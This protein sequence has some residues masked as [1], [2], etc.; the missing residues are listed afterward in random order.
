MPESASSPLDDPPT[1]PATEVKSV[2]EQ[3]EKASPPHFS[4]SLSSANFSPNGDLYD[5]LDEDW[6][7]SS[8]LGELSLFD[9]LDGLSIVPVTLDRFNQRLKI[10]SREVY[11]QLK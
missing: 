7:L 10:Q 4:R 8:D 6:L 9:F 5:S 11:S 3:Q 2:E 1:E